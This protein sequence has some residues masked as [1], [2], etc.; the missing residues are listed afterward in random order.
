M[1]GVHL[2][3][4]GRD[5]V[6]SVRAQPKSRR[7]RAVGVQHGARVLEGIKLWWWVVGGAKWWSVVGLSS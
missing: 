7:A 3:A 1:Y 2:I 4:E 5:S 6:G